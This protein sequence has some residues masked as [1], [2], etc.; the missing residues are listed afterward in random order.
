MKKIDINKF[1]GEKEFSRINIYDR[2]VFASDGNIIIATNTLNCDFRNKKICNKNLLAG[3]FLKL[4]PARKV[5]LE[6]KVD[7]I[8]NTEDEAVIKVG[9]SFIRKSVLRLLLTET[10]EKLRVFADDEPLSP[11]LFSNI[12]SDVIGIVLSCAIAEEE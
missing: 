10:G 11:L 7:D 5:E 1:I 4:K 3:L 9:Q 8:L 6:I 12:D 2:N